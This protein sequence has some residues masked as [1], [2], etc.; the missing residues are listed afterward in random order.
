MEPSSIINEAEQPPPDMQ[1]QA[2]WW[3]INRRTALRWRN[4]GVPLH[5]R[6]MTLAWWDKQDQSKLPQGFN[7]RCEELRGNQKRDLPGESD[8]DW[9]EFEAQARTDDPKEAMA[10]ISR[11]R[12]WAYFKLEKA[13]KLDD[14][15]GQKF[16]SD[17]LAKMESTLHD[18]QLRAKKMGLD[19]GELIPRP[20]IERIIWA[21]AFWLMRSSSKHLD[22]ISVKLAAKFPS[23]EA[24]DVRDV[25]EPELLSDRFLI[26]YARASKIASGV[27]IPDWL[28]SEMRKAC[29]DFLEKGEAAFDAEAE[30]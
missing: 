14:N 22:A 16:Y 26:P 5:S 13:A 20:E 25:L 3:R 11:A 12:D 1:G 17:L 19:E 4:Q 15:K 21:Q 6:E 10:K 29:G 2:A 18:A 28:V 24:K 30:K 8:R 27:T 9:A 7:A 23:V